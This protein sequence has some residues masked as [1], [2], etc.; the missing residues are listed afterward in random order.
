MGKLSQ[1][2][3]NIV[4]AVDGWLRLGDAAEAERELTGLPAE[5]VDEP[6]VLQARWRLACLKEQWEK[7]E[8]IAR[9]LT[10]LEPGARFGWLHLAD[11]YLRMGQP[12]RAFLTLREVLE[13]FDPNPTL[14]FHMAR[15]ASAMGDAEEGFRWF[16]VAMR[17]AE[18]MADP[19]ALLRRARADELLA[20]IRDR[21][22]LEENEDI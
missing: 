20:P 3:L 17:L 1:R 22:S 21:L 18:K 10:A 2:D 19:Q 7:C 9:R 11:A 6:P 8:S 16:R 12:E 14:P 13:R 5:S 15:Y 4:R